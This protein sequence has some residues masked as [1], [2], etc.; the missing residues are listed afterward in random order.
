MT[1]SDVIRFCLCQP[2]P[3]YIEENIRLR[4]HERN[5]YVWDYKYMLLCSSQP[6]LVLKNDSKHSHDT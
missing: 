4:V 2:T 3:T 6:V 1:V 5:V